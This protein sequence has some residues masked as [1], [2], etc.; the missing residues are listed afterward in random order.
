M[1]SSDCVA[2]ANSTGTAVASP[3]RASARNCLDASFAFAAGGHF[4][5]GRQRGRVA[6]I[7]QC[8]QRQGLTRC[9]LPFETG[10]QHARRVDLLAQLPGNMQRDPETA[11]RLPIRVTRQSET[12]RPRPMRQPRC[13]SRPIFVYCETGAFCRASHRATALS[14]SFSLVSFRAQ[15]KQAF[16]IAGPNSGVTSESC[17]CRISAVAG[18][19]ICPSARAAAAAI[20]AIV[21]TEQFRDRVDRFD[22]A[23][24]ADGT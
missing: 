10:N 11:I 21:A 2:A 1:R 6:Q 16:P 23:A 22:V 20:A 13:G 12:A 9:R 19:P 18:V 5:Y 3:S 7:T 24:C 8:D 17:I 14:V 15:I 4:Q